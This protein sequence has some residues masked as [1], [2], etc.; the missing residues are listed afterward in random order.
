MPT[1]GAR[2]ALRTLR[3]LIGAAEVAPEALAEGLAYARRVIAEPDSPDR[4]KRAALQTIQFAA[5][6]LGEWAIQV[7]AIESGALEDRTIHVVF[8]D[9]PPADTEGDKGGAPR[10]LVAE[11]EGDAPCPP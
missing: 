3:R 8:S 1:T 2:A 11:D 4:D 6:Q 10:Q 7:D 9:T 5:R